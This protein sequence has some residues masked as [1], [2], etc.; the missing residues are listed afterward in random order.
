MGVFPVDEPLLALPAGSLLQFLLMTLPL[1]GVYLYFLWLAI[2]R[3][4][5]ANPNDPRYA[6]DRIRLT[7]VLWTYLATLTLFAS[8]AVYLMWFV[9][10][11]RRLSK[12]YE[13]EGIVILGNVEYH[14]HVH[15]PSGFKGCL[16]SL[17]R[18]LLNGCHLQ[19]N[20][21]T[22]VYNL[23]DVARHPSCDWEERKRKELKGTIRKRVRVYYRY[24]RERVSL[25]VLPSRPKS[26]QPKADMEADWASFVEHVG[27]P[28]EEDREYMSRPENAGCGN[29]PGVLR[30]DRSLGVLLV[31]AFWMIFLLLASLYVVGQIVKIE[32]Y[33]T[34]EDGRTAWIIF[35]SWVGGGVPLVAV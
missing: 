3:P 12:R 19:N 26:G 27:L 18:F 14:E 11:R 2:D 20:Y 5:I 29:A 7:D 21:G 22:A 8:L 25:L 6:D 13:S 35:W 32:D 9:G 30:R 1:L 28:T 24:P 31:S 4:N 23:E 16:H 10:K 15:D 34:D 17:K 33:Y